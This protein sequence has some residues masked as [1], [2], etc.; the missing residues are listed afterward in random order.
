[1]K[2]FTA[3]I[4]IF[5]LLFSLSSCKL[6]TEGNS[7]ST[8]TQRINALS[9]Y[10]L[11][12]IGYIYNEKNNTLSKFYTLEGKNILLSFK[13]NNENDLYSMNIVF[14]NINKNNTLVIKFASDCIR[15]FVNNDD[16]FARLIA[17]EKF[18]SILTEKSNETKTEK[19]GSIELL[20]DTTD[21]GVVI[22]VN[23][24]L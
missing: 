18:I 5:T 2:T 24:D 15:A 9:D 16:I 6:Q 19:I 8:F 7:L 1:M 10:E 20:V 14:D 13:G 11:T 3:I 4:L 17:P 22:T 23:K 12:S 21:V